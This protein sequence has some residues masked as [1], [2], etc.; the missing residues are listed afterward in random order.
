MSADVV[1]NRLPV[2]NAIQFELE[3]KLL[4]IY[5]Q[6]AMLWR[7]SLYNDVKSKPVGVPSEL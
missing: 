6:A 3:L 7:M 5:L 2:G 4:I 1:S